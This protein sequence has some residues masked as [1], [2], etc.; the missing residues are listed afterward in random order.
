MWWN[1]NLSDSKTQGSTHMSKVGG[2]KESIRLINDNLKQNNRR[3]EVKAHCYSM[4]KN[5]CEEPGYTGRNRCVRAGTR[6]RGSRYKTRTK[7]K[8][9]KISTTDNKK[10]EKKIA[11]LPIP[12]QNKKVSCNNTFQV[13]HRKQKKKC[14]KKIYYICTPEATNFF[15]VNTNQELNIYESKYHRW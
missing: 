7:N 6:E 12:Q 5:T 9:V 4:V 2:R 13:N 11:M 3:G 10:T 14:H 1:S 8:W 15:H